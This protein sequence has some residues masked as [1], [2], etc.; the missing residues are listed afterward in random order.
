MAFIKYSSDGVDSKFSDDED[1]FGFKLNRIPYKNI[2]LSEY[3]E[4]DIVG[5]MDGDWLC[6]SVCCSLSEYDGIHVAKDRINDKVNHFIEVSGCNKLIAFCG[7]TGNYRMDLL[8]PKKINTTTTNSGRYKDNRRDTTP[9]RFLKEIKEWFMRKYVSWWSVCMEADD[10]IVMSNVYLTRKG[11]KSFIYGIDKDYNQCH[12]G[13]LYLVGHHDTPI[14][15]EDNYENR[16]GELYIDYSTS[17]KGKVKGHGDKFL[18]Y[19]ALTEDGADNY[20]CKNFLKN[21]FD[22]GNF[23][24]KDAVDYINQAV[25]R[26]H[27]WKLYLKRFEDKLPNKFKYEAWNGDIIE[28]N[29]FLVADLYFKCA[30]MIREE[31]V[32][33][34]LGSYLKGVWSDK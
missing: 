23:G 2:D 6:Y 33:P 28:S 1:S 13:G 26:K 25:D 19:Q 20:S 34:D 15:F 30:C 24:D 7:S 12:G 29:R 10:C 9:P 31:G 4:S 16:F 22:A 32:I 21:N 3:T 27:L 17:K 11:I 18:V 8:L 5:L 14:F